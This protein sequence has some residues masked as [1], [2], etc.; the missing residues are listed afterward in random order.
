MISKVASK[1]FTQRAV[2]LSSKRSI[3]HGGVFGPPL[4]P[5]SII[6]IKLEN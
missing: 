6:V 1:L 3:T 4:R 2:T 5:N